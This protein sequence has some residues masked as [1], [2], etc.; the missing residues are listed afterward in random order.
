[1]PPSRIIR[2]KAAPAGIAVS[3]QPLTPAAFR[4]YGRIIAM[5]DR[6]ADAQGNFWR[7]IVRER[8]PVGWRIAYLIVSQK[9]IEYLE[10]HPDSWESFEPVAG[11]AV[12][13]VGTG[14][15]PRRLR[16]FVLDKPVVL[17]RGVWHGL[18]AL[19]S[20]AQIKITENN[21]VGMRRFRLPAALAGMVARQG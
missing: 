2:N 10:Q 18:I 9:S 17:R 21:H 13:Y 12:L 5:D 20:R 1:M 16:C 11:R 6:P 3:P 14:N 19:S 7:V 15:K 8:R 4:R